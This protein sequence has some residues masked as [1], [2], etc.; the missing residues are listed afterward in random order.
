MSSTDNPYK[1]EK[2]H[3]ALQWAEIHFS[4]RRSANYGGLEKTREN[5]QTAIRKAML[6]RGKDSA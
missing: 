3:E 1:R 4:P 2:I 5:L 6:V